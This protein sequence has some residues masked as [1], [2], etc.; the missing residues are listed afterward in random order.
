M[1]GWGLHVGLL[2]IN[3]MYINTCSNYHFHFFISLIL[4]DLGQ[5]YPHTIFNSQDFYMVIFYAFCC[6]Y[7]WCSRGVPQQNCPNP[8]QPDQKRYCLQKA[9]W[10]ADRSADSSREEERSKRCCRL[11]LLPPVCSQEL[12]QDH[13]LIRLYRAWLHPPISSPHCSCP[14]SK[15]MVGIQTGGRRAGGSPHLLWLTPP[16]CHCHYTCS[17]EM[18][19]VGNLC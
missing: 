12:T 16:L 2:W 7:Q 17:D 15:K 6:L 8:L 1:L 14:G 4:L 10:V 9:S 5:W 19:V 18:H 13:C 11:C 3:K